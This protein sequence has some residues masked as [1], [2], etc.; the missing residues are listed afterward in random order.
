MNAKHIVSAL[1]IAF[2]AGSAMAIEATQFDDTPSTLTR[3][4]VKAEMLAAQAEQSVVVGGEATVFVD[5]PVAS[6]GRDREDVRTEAR[7]AGREHTFNELYVG[8]A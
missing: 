4:E 2:A 1:S 8:A 3:A 5:A 6:V 7:I